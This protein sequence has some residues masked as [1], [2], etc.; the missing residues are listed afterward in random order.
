MSGTE[1]TRI[2]AATIIYVKAV[3]MRGTTS[4]AMIRG[5]VGV[6]CSEVIS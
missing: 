1:Q 2:H 3:T 5:K 6:H 4:T